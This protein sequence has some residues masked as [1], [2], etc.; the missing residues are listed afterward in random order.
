MYLK[1]LQKVVTD[2]QNILRKTC[3]YYL[4]FTVNGGLYIITLGRM[5]SK[6]FFIELS[7]VQT[8][9]NTYSTIYISNVIDVDSLVRLRSQKDVCIVRYKMRVNTTIVHIISIS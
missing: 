1:K 8:V 6:I 7:C 2:L 4:L 9:T 5:C 3:F